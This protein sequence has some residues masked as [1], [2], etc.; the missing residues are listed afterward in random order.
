VKLHLYP[1]QSITI[2]AQTIMGQSVFS[3]LSRCNPSS[4][5]MSSCQSSLEGSFGVISVLIFRRCFFLQDLRLRSK[6]PTRSRPTLVLTSQ[7]DNSLFDDQVSVLNCIIL[8]S[9]IKH[10]IHGEKAYQVSFPT[11]LAHIIW[12]FLG[13]VI[14]KILKVAQK[15]NSHTEIS[16]ADLPKRLLHIST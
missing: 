3:S 14:V 10:A 2:M 5:G 15:S 4:Q 6:P 11:H 13:E 1:L 9:F 7:K 12:R 16:S 8:R